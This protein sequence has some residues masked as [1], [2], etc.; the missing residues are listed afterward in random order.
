MKKQPSILTIVGGGYIAS[1]LAHFYGI[2]GTKINIIQR[3][4]VLVPREDEEVAN[5]FTE[6]FS[7]KYNIYLGYN[8]ESASKD[9]VGNGNDGHLFRVTAKIASGKKIEIESDQLLIAA[10]RV[11][12]SDRLDL[13]KTNAR[14]DERGF[15]MVNSYLETNINGIFALCDAVGRYMF[16][17]AANHEAQYAYN[18]ILHPDRKVA[19][20]YGVMP[21]SIFSSPQ[22][23]AVGYTEQ[24]L[25]KQKIEYLRLVNPYIHTAMARQLKTVMALSSSW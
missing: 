18:N 4:D 11:P 24:D 19:V 21:H 9:E 25:K 23:A 16:E 7:K 12:N 6:I 1:E 17:H 5:K 20:D 10:G 22:I 8:T 15:I 14:T 13:G 2:L 3:N